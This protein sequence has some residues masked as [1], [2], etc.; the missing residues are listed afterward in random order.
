MKKYFLKS[1][2]LLA[3]NFIFI[4]MC[5]A[6]SVI[7][8]FI[9]RQIT[10]IS[11]GGEIDRLKSVLYLMAGYSVLMGILGFIKRIL[12]RLFIKNTMYNLKKDIFNNLISRKISSFSL[13]NSANYISAINNDTGIVEQEYFLS[14][15]D[16]FDYVITFIIAT[17]AIF[18]LNTYVAIAI[19]LSGFI[20]MLVPTIFQ[21][22]LGK[23]KKEYSDGIG[24]FTTKIKDIFTGFEVIKSFNIEEKIKEDFQHSNESLE[25]KKYRSGFFESI[26]NTISEFFGFVVFF[27]PLGLGTYLTLN[28]Q[29]TAGGMVASV[30]LTN[31]IVNPVLNFSY[32]LTKIKGAKPINE[33]L[34]NM[35]NESNGEEEG[36]SKEEFRELIQFE[37]ISFSYNE[38]RKILDNISFSINKGEKIAIVGKSGSGKSTLLKLLLRYYENYDGEIKLDDKSIK[39]ISLT[40]LYKLI[41][42]IQQN[43]FMFDDSIKANVALYGD[44][45]DEEIDNAIRNSGLEELL[46]NLPMGKDSSVGENGSN[47]SGGEKQRISIARALVKNTPIILLDEA[48][49]SLDSKTAYEIEN[50]LLGIEGLTS[51]VITHKLS[52]ELL[53][54]YDKILVLDKGQIIEMGSFDELIDEEGYFYSLFNVEKAA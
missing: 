12:R 24:S 41:S 18:K 27:V 54:K 11:Y 10:D 39:D 2:T 3:L 4:T 31:Y 21:K 49:G 47:L 30:Q 40:S 26:A 16:S 35:I 34:C 43:V 25:T 22:E 48:T 8:A 37:N 50:S 33:K 9:L 5:S 52:E 46:K 51:I 38:E 7:L 13:E 45:T 42:I 20:P 19:L 29:F 53:S 44:Y 36:A 17:F 14:L 6:S 15:L 28:G 32:I 1:K 23:R